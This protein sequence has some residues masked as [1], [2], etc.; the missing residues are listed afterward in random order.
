MR[1]M[2]IAIR[3][4]QDCLL[5]VSVDT[6]TV[7]TTDTTPSSSQTPHHLGGTPALQVWVCGCVTV[8]IGVC[9]CVCVGGV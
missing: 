9:E 4:W 5:G 8:C 7:D 2:A 1:R 6:A 3:A